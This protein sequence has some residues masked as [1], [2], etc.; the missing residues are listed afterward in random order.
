[1]TEKSISQC[2]EPL[3]HGGGIMMLHQ[4]GVLELTQHHDSGGALGPL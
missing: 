2:R 1:M 3:Q 4:G